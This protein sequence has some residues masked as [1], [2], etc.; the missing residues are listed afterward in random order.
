MVG[1]AHGK[2][3]SGAV[4][5]FRR[6][7][8][9]RPARI[10]LVGP[11]FS[12]HVVRHAN[13]LAKEGFDVHLTS[14]SSSVPAPG[15]HPAIAIHQ[16]DSDERPARQS[17]RLSR[18]QV[19]VEVA[20][21][22]LGAM[23]G[24]EG[25]PPRPDTLR[26]RFGRAS[27]RQHPPT[28]VSCDSADPILREFR[29][30]PVRDI[31][32]LARL[33]DDLQPDLIHSLTLQYGGYPVLQA[34]QQTTRRFPCWIV[35]NWGADVHYWATV[36]GHAPLI[37]D[38]L[39]GADYLFAICQRDVALSRAHG[40][41][42]R[43]MA[44]ETPGG[45]WDLAAITQLRQPGATSARRDLVI[46]GYDGLVGRASVALRAIETLGDAMQGRRLVILAPGGDVP[47]QARK[48]GQSLGVEVVVHPHV[49]YQ[50]VLGALGRARVFVG[51]SIT[52]A[53]PTMAIESMMMG[54]F[55][56]YSDT[57][58]LEELIDSGRSGL[59]APPE[60]PI[61]VARAIRRALV[62]D[63]L[64]D[65]GV[66]WNDRHVV[67]RFDATVLNP[68]IVDAYER[69]LLAERRGFFGSIERRVGAM[70]PSW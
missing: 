5:P 21:R 57:G 32:W 18:I 62:D 54:A 10:L 17:Q 47:N 22:R 59:L 11:I 14:A 8:R 2:A 33:I 46:K 56:V 67:P 70:R 60:D 58:A 27:R 3:G 38:V 20:A 25:Q 64:V 44:L 29:L 6:L 49:S 26:H 55:P 4:T 35:G 51:L 43:L 37:R 45:G 69:V 16:P 1:A 30:D 39:S 65:A 19:R 15:F 68:K 52:D 23:A 9:V 63:R 12:Q 24:V 41:N 31:P 7:A 50:D 40:F 66:A 34:R 13:I 28:V 36:P 42:G 48:I 53:W 61:M